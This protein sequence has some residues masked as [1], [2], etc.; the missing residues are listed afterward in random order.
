MDQNLLRKDRTN[1]TALSFNYSLYGCSSILHMLDR[2]YV[3]ALPGR[4]FGI[5]LLVRGVTRTVVTSGLREKQAGDA[6]L[7][8][9]VR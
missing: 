6:T 4:G 5:Q 9:L 1:H 7:G 3:R 8:R 2:F